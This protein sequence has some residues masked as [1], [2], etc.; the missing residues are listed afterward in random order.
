VPLIFIT[1]K[2]LGEPVTVPVTENEEPAV[3][4]A[5]AV[6]TTKYALAV[7]CRRRIRCRSRIGVDGDIGGRYR[8]ERT[9]HKIQTG[10]D[11]GGG[12]IGQADRDS[13]SGAEALNAP[14]VT[15][16]LSTATAKL[17]A[18]SVVLLPSK[19]TEK[20]GQRDGRIRQFKHGTQ[21][22]IAGVG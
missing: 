12:T 18:E 2:L 9:E 22:E 8:K 17:E 13:Q 3:T 16:A 21:G 20:L 11:D 7:V 4:V 10:S 15:E 6:P 14:T 19:V 1:E 5:E